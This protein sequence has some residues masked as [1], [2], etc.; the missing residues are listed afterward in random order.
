MLTSLLY[1]QCGGRA[2]RRGT[3]ATRSRIVYGFYTAAF[4]FLQTVDTGIVAIN[5][6][7][8]RTVFTHNCYVVF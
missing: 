8:E 4:F 5:L 6:G 2:G 1:Q 7:I 3:E